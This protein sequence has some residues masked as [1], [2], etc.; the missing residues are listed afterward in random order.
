[1]N[2]K[3]NLWYIN[4]GLII[5]SIAGLSTQ[6]GTN[7]KII[8]SGQTRKYLIHIPDSYNPENPTPLVISIHGFV[9]WPANQQSVSR[10]NDVADENGFLVVYPKGTGFPLRWNTRPSQDG[11]GAMESE[12]QFF[13]DLLDHLTKSYNIDP[14]RI[15]VNGMSNGGGMSDLLACKLSDRIA[16]FGA[17]AGAYVYPRDDCHPSHPMPVIAFHGV[18]DQI[19]NYQGGASSRDDA[20][21]FPAVEDWAAGWAELNSCSTT[22][23]ISLITNEINRTHYSG[24]EENAAVILYSISNG[25]HTWPGG[26]KLPVWIAGYTNPDIHASALMWEFFREYSLKVE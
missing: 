16:A 26:R 18:D 5:L 6:F 15:Y 2:K 22:P 19:V 23:E 1:M 10:W 8:S 25:G 21:V 20:F 11:S 9:Q 4:I 24:C 3:K 14:A 13:T 12:L 17:V 7:G